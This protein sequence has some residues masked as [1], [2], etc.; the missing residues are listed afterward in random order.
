MIELAIEISFMFLLGISLGSFSNVLIYRIPSEKSIIKPGST[1]V[2]GSKIPFYHNIPIVSYFVLGGVSHCCGKKISVQYP[3]VEFLGGIIF[4]IVYYKLGFALNTILIGT[5]F[6]LLLVLSVIDMK[7]LVAYDSINLTTLTLALFAYGNILENIQN[8]LLVGGALTFL[9]FYLSFL[10]KKEA[11]GEGDII[12]GGTMGALL[13]IKLSFVAVFVSAVI[14]L[15][16]MITLVYILK[17]DPEVPYIPF[18]AFATFTVFLFDSDFYN[19]I[20]S[21]Y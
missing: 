16:I 2:C 21:V 10:L 12:I 14:A 4:L 5:I 13:G 17:K 8:A 18:L 15:P 20:W 3:I 6:T 19:F 7:F 1:C 11:M 9:R